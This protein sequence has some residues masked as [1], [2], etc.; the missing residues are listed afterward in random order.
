MEPS[1]HKLT[2]TLQTLIFTYLISFPHHSLAGCQKG[3]FCQCGGGKSEVKGFGKEL[4][5]FSKVMLCYCISWWWGNLCSHPEEE[6]R[7]VARAGCCVDSFTGTSLSGARRNPLELTL[8]WGTNSSM[9]T[10][11]NFGRAGSKHTTDLHPVCSHGDHRPVLSRDLPV[12]LC[13]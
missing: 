8:P 13:I 2:H 10:Q 9:F 11:V 6:Q 4:A 12:A 3:W 5:S 1:I 7:R